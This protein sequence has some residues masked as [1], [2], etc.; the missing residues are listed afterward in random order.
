MGAHVR[1]AEELVERLAVLLD[2]P[3]AQPAAC[4]LSNSI[5][6]CRSGPAGGASIT[7]L[8]VFAAASAAPALLHTPGWLIAGRTAA[9]VGAAL[10]MPSTLS[11]ITAGFPESRRGDAVGLWAGVAGAGA[12]LQ[13][14]E[15]I[16]PQAAP[17]ADFAE[18]ASVHVAQQSALALGIVTFV[19]AA[20]IRVWAPGRSRATTKPAPTRPE[21]QPTTTP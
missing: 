8:F 19:A 13:V 21:T 18:S 3:P 14:T 11:L 17:L 2:E 16:G 1:I 7:G 4:L 6:R 10:V 12:V 20:L 15:R 9:G 5:S